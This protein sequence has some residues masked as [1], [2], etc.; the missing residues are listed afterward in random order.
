MP[1]DETG[2]TFALR[3][4]KLSSRVTINKGRLLLFVGGSLYAALCERKVL[5]LI[6]F[7]EKTL[8]H[9]VYKSDHISLL[10]MAFVLLIP[11]PAKRILVISIIFKLFSQRYPVNIAFS[12]SGRSP[13]SYFSC[14]VYRVLA[15]ALRD[16]TKGHVTRGNFSCN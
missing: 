14:V 9:P 4:H 16:D 5:F 7:P 11:H 10:A 6:P 13:K 3:S 15:G 8:P 1:N 12:R 2:N